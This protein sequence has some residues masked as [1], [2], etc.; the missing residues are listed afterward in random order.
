MQSLRQFQR[1]RPMRS[2]HDNPANC[3]PAPRGALPSVPHPR[4]SRAP[5]PPN[6]CTVAGNAMRSTLERMASDNLA[7]RTAQKPSANGITRTCGRHW[8]GGACVCA[9]SDLP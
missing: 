7:S 5:K 8:T 3:I 1:M 2:R 9:L 6:W 4:S